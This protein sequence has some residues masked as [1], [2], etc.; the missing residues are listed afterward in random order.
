[1]QLWRRFLADRR[2]K[3]IEDALTLPVLLLVTF[4]LLNVFQFGLAGVVAANAANYGARM[5]AVAQANSAQVA[6]QAAWQKLQASRLP[7]GRFTVSV[8]ASDER[9]SVVVVRVTY[10]VPNY[11][12]RLATLFGAH[13]PAHLT[14]Q[15]EGRFRHEGW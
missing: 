11:A 10:R 1:M 3:L 2:G 9:G 5:G 8:E 6:A 14:G 12:Y 13:L 4:G 7:Q 15:A